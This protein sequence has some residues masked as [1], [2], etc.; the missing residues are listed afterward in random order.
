MLLVFRNSLM[1]GMQLELACRDAGLDLDGTTE[2]A[3]KLDQHIKG[4]SRRVS[5]HNPKHSNRRRGKSPGREAPRSLPWRGWNQSPWNW[6]LP[7]LRLRKEGGQSPKGSAFTVVARG[8]SLQPAP[9][10]KLRQTE[11]E[12]LHFY[13][14][15]YMFLSFCLCL[16]C[17]CLRLP[18]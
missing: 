12:H 13:I 10:K 6:E 9:H 2:L 1:E 4:K 7:D 11:Y 14:I 5:S 3:I 15:S 18:L 8:I 17:L 16:T